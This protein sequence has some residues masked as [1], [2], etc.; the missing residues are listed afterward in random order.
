[1]LDLPALHRRARRVLPECLHTCGLVLHEATPARIA[2]LLLP[3]RHV[4]RGSLRF[5]LAPESLAALATAPLAYL[6]D[7]VEARE[8]LGCRRGRLA[9]GPWQMHGTAGARRFVS[10][11]RDGRAAL[12]V[13][14][15]RRLAV[16]A[17]NDRRRGDGEA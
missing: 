2:S 5:R 14:P 7:A 15:A 16:Y 17:W 12:C 4:R 8:G 11:S 9:Y 13:I 3:L 10:R 1:M 6:R